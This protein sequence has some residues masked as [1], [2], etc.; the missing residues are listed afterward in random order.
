MS[1]KRKAKAK[2]QPVSRLA[3]FTLTAT[4]ILLVGLNGI[5]AYMCIYDLNPQVGGWPILRVYFREFWIAFAAI[6]I[7]LFLPISLLNFRYFTAAKAHRKVT[8]YAKICI[9]LCFLPGL[10]PLV[11]NLMLRAVQAF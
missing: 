8:W 10:L 11:A 3:I 5:V 4:F 2:P 9:P 1:S 7:V 6:G